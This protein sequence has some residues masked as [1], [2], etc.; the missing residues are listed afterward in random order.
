M[1]LDIQSKFFYI[2]AYAF[3]NFFGL[4]LDMHLLTIKNPTY[5]HSCYAHQVEH[6]RL[7]A[8]KKET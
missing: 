5:M 1:H 3:M 2:V 6:V 8:P 4:L 7:C